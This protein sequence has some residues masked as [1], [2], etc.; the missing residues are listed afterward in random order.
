MGL[1][2]GLD[3]D[4]LELKVTET[5]M[6]EEM[7]A[8]ICTLQQLRDMGVSVALD[9][10]STGYSSL[11]FLRTLPFDRVKIDRSFVQE[12]GKKPQATVI[13]RS[14]AGMCA[15]LGA[16]VTVE[17]VETD[18]QIETL[19]GIGCS[20]IQ[21]Y[22]IGRPCSKVELADWLA[23]LPRV[24][25]ARVENDPQRKHERGVT[26]RRAFGGTNSSYP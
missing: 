9:D 12:L 10:F 23:A 2:I 13:V 8:A 19:R 4:R 14:I 16:S 15:D 25:P 7:E 22:R 18:E 3:P 1:A 5:A 17:G 26:S 21:G 24:I 11:S 20:E 6:I